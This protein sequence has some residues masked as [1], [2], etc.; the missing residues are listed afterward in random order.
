MVE[1]LSRTNGGR[2]KHVRTMVVDRGDTGRGVEAREVKWSV[3]RS[4]ARC[5]PCDDDEKV[6]VSRDVADWR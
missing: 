6:L 2:L 4:A 1:P 5:G 3:A